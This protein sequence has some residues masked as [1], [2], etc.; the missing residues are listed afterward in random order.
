MLLLLLFFF[1]C[2]FFFSILIICLN[3]FSGIYILF[4]RWL[5][6]SLAFLSS[7]FIYIL[8]SVSMLEFFWGTVCQY[9]LV[10]I[11]WLLRD[12]V[13]TH[14]MSED[15]SLCQ[16]ICLW[17]GNSF[18]IQVI[19]QVRLVLTSFTF[20]SALLSLSCGHTGVC[21]CVSG[22]ILSQIWGLLR[23]SLFFSE[24]ACGLVHTHSLPD[25]NWNMWELI[26]VIKSAS[27]PGLPN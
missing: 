21:V 6:M 14:W 10:V 2:F 11:G 5:L 20:Q 19:I 1:V 9:T 8:V 12:C 4:G 22:F 3:L 16:E 24:Y 17:L 18:K 23:C 26:K 7:F 15:S 25:S 27:F 13:Q